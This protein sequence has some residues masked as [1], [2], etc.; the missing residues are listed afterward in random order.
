[1]TTLFKAKRSIKEAIDAYQDPNEDPLTKALQPHPDETEEERLHRLE[2]AKAAVK[3][4]REIDAE[5]LESK[6]SLE[7]KNKAIKILLL[8][9][10]SLQYYF[11]VSRRHLRFGQDKLNQERVQF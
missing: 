6:K 4:S 5:I 11:F 3:V 2:S 1:M 8:G 7:Q 9:K 10:V